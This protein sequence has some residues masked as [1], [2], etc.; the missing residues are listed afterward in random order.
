MD[1]P[2]FITFVIPTAPYHEAAAEHAIAS[3][4]AQTILC[5][6]VVSYDAERRGA[7]W[8]RNRGLEQVST[9]FV[10][11]LDADDWIEPDF[12]EKCLLAYDGWR[13]VY[14]DWWGWGYDA[15]TSA[16]IPERKNAPCRAWINE[17]PHII[18]TLLPTN[19]VRH[20]GGF[21]ETMPFC[22]DT[23]F[24]IKLQ[25]NGLCGKIL[26]LPLFHYGKEG[27]RA[28]Q[29]FVDGYEPETGNRQYT[30]KY[31]EIMRLIRTRYE[32][33]TMP[34]N[35]TDCG[36]N[37]LDIPDAPIGE[38]QSG[39]VLAEALWMGNRQERGRMTGRLYPRTGNH[40]RLWVD[41]RDI[42]AAPTMFARVIELPPPVSGDDLKAFRQFS[43]DVREAFGGSARD[44]T[45]EPVPAY[46]PQGEAAPDVDRVL[47]LYNR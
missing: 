16:Y 8:A 45:Q 1:R 38:P 39:D 42:D 34:S 30:P 2:P 33:L 47:R 14:T 15:A 21:D 29:Q 25:R 22:E 3:C 5:R 4:L 36:G 23:D 12:A 32:G 43:A 11:F 31:H 41:P 27:K 44:T 35:C 9:P 40:K 37:P 24:Y 28:Q 13:Y 18:T 6:V 19:F 7:G 46:V 20:Y 26:P 17:Q 10:S